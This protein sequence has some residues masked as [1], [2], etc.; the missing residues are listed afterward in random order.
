MLNKKATF[1]WGRESILD[2]EDNDK[3]SQSKMASC[4]H[5]GCHC[6]TQGNECARVPGWMPSSGENASAA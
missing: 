1:L 4:I 5:S 2:D 6:E 3:R